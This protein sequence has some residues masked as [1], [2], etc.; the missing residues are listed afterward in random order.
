MDAYRET[1]HMSLINNV[2]TRKGGVYTFQQYYKVV[3]EVSNS[4]SAPS[5]ATS[6]TRNEMSVTRNERSMISR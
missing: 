3:A 1:L 5:K 4:R 6:S 2:V